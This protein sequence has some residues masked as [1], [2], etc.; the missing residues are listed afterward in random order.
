MEVR[1]ACNSKDFVSYDTKWLRN[2]FL[3]TDLFTLGETKVVY[4]HNDRIL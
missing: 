2:D 4:S 1:E 3:I